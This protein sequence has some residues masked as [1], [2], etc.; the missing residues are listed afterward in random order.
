MPRC[1]FRLRSILFLFLAGSAFY[2][3]ATVKAHAQDHPPPSAVAQQASQVDKDKIIADLVRRVEALERRLANTNSAA[4]A[5][6]PIAAPAAG[7]LTATPLLPTPPATPAPRSQPPSTAV[8]AT[9]PASSANEPADEE[10]SRALERTLIREGG[11]VLPPKTFEIEP[12]LSYDYYS[13]NALQIVTIGGQ[14]QVSQQAMRRGLAQATLGL[15]VGLPWATQL[16]MALPY[17]SNRERLTTIGGTDDTDRASGFG[18]FE[19]GL[20]KQIIN[21]SKG[22][23]GLLGS[24]RWRRAGSGDDFGSPVAVSSGFDLLQGALTVVKRQDPMVFFGSLSHAMTYSKTIDGSRIEPGNVTGAKVGSILAVS[25]DTSMRF[26]FEFS[27]IAETSINGTPVAGSD[28]I[29]GLFN[30]G[31][32]FVLTPK[33]LLGIEAGIGL[34]SRSPDFRLGI[35]L[36]IRF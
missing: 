18:N 1:F 30:T 25:P 6:P 5:V 16:E 36:P 17:S 8:A 4:S 26:G 12:R 19:I 24:L 34:T 22:T 21:E 28:A 11:L 20:T 27:R 3:G 23:P 7:P 31:L 9:G 10:T 14:A 35:S 13:S 15:R 2:G 32:S 33:T 29:V